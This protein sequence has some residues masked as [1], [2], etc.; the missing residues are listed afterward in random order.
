M[1]RFLHTFF[2]AIAH[3]DFRSKIIQTYKYLNKHFQYNPRERSICILRKTSCIVFFL[4]HHHDEKKALMEFQFEQMRPAGK[5]TKTHIR[6]GI[7]QRFNNFFIIIALLCIYFESIYENFVKAHRVRGFIY[8]Y[9][10]SLEDIFI[11]IVI[12]TQSLTSFSDFIF[13]NLW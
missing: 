2:H 9:R 11:L 7:K 10:N 6:N 1:H 12:V 8:G 4:D 3:R 5:S 13:L